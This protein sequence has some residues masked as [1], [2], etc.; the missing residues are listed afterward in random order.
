MSMKGKEE[1]GIRSKDGKVNREGKRIG[2]I[3]KG[4]GLGYCKRR[5]TGG[6]VDVHGERSNSVIDYVLGDEKIRREIVKFEVGEGLESDHHPLIV[7]IRKGRGGKEKRKRREGEGWKGR[8]I[9]DEEKRETFKRKMEGMLGRGES[10]KR[11][12]RRGDKKGNGENRKR[13]ERKQREEKGRMVGQRVYGE[14]KGG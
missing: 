13:G 7:T 4:E 2:K 6:G 8:G 14:E 12:G 5:G 3:Y 1:D 10:K 9:W 11:W